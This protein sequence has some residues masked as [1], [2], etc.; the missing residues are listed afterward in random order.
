MSGTISLQIDT[1]LL[2]GFPGMDRLRLAAALQVELENLIRSRGLPF[3]ESQTREE[4]QIGLLE[5]PAGVRPEQLG[6]R[7]AQAVY[8]ELSR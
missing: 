3:T 2:E 1:L 4:L 7:L 8:Q 5:V 6:A